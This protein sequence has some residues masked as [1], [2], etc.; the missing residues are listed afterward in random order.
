MRCAG[1]GT[2]PARGASRG[3]RLAPLLAD[4][5]GE[6]EPDHGFIASQPVDQTQMLLVGLQDVGLAIQ[7]W[8]AGS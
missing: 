2:P 5:T 8:Q 6:C 1:L 3:S 7:R 4:V